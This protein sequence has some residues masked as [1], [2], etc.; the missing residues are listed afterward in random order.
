MDAN[1][2]K[3]LKKQAQE[4]G[5]T[6]VVVDVRVLRA[7]LDE[8]VLDDPDLDATD[9]AHPAWWRGHDHVAARMGAALTDARADAARLRERLSRTDDAGSTSSGALHPPQKGGV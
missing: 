4:Q 3:T 1:D 9:A 5:V 7:L 2:L 8:F 6:H